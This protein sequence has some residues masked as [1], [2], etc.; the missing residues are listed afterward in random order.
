MDSIDVLNVLFG[1]S[2]T[3]TKKTSLFVSVFTHLNSRFKS[4]IRRDSI[5]W[6][7]YLSAYLVNPIIT[8]SWWLHSFTPHLQSINVSNDIS[9]EN[10][11]IISGEGRKS[12]YMDCFWKNTNPGDE[13]QERR[14]K[15]IIYYI[16]DIG[17]LSFNF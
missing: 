3:Y 12:R 7:K 14:G 15:P 6:S 9:M 10:Q 1:P 5:Y 4:S 8:V 13:I 17:E 16:D 11:S 2:K